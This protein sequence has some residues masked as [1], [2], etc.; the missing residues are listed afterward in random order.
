M[1]VCLGVC[2]YMCV[3]RLCVYVCVCLC[4][5]LQFCKNL[6]EFHYNCFEAL[7]RFYRDFCLF[8]CF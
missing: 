8:V 3:F 5:F 1:C 4:V 6:T 2:V 7:F